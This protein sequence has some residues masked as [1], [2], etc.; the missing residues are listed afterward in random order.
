MDRSPIYVWDILL[1]I[2]K[3]EKINAVELSEKAARKMTFRSA[4]RADGTLFY[5][6]LGCI[7]AMLAVLASYRA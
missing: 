6:S 7:G 5:Q 4:L 2:L 1:F 3:K